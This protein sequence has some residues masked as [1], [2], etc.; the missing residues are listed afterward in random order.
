MSADN[1]EHYTPA[2]LKGLPPQT[3]LQLRVALGRLAEPEEIA[4]A[5]AFLVSPDA[6]YVTGSTMGVDGGWS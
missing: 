6:S 1:L 5:V 4:A 2:A 3:L